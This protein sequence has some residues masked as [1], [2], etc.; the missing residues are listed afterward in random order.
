MT[1]KTDNTVATQ[2]VRQSH[3]SFDMDSGYWRQFGFGI[4][5]VY[6]SDLRR[7]GGFDTSIIGWG[8]EDVDLYEKFINSNLTIVRSV[9]P[10]LVHV[11]HRIE[12]DP[13]LADEQMIMC[14]G[15]KSTSISSQRVLANLIYDKRMHL[16]EPRLE[17]PIAKLANSKTAAKILKNNVPLDKH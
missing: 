13:G 10:G 9:D 2:K 4:V 3:F 12:C 15:S 17:I 16:I 1:N 8:K 14:M 6:N 11:F 7:V 5:C